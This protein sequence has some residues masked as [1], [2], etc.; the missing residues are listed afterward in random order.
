MGWFLDIL[1]EYLFRVAVR[2]IKLLRSHNWP[3]TKG[4]VLSVTCPAPSFGCSVATVE[5][6][7]TVDGVKHRA[8]Y[9]KPFLV[10]GSGVAYA[11]LSVKGADFKVHLKPSNPS[12][13]VA[14]AGGWLQ[15]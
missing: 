3:I 8:S 4:T 1:F 10:H 9:E 6:E 11:D 13:S 7:Y 2:E 5:Y 12:V 14:E 15:P